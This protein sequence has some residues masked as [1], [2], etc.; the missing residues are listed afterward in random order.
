[1]LL[2]VMDRAG[3]RWMVMN[4]ELLVKSFQIH[5]CLIKLWPCTEDSLE[6][7]ANTAEDSWK[8]IEVLTKIFIGYYW[9]QSALE[10]E[11]I[12]RTG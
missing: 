10:I 1:M 11:P 7:S 6:R 9:G 2:D 5:V 3:R 8:G 12:V 4:S